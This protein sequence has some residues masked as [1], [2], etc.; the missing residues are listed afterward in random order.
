[1]LDFF[2]NQFYLLE[3]I[4][5]RHTFPKVLRFVW[6][7]FYFALAFWTFYQNKIIIHLRKK[8]FV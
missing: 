7:F 1:M 8:N 2:F 6:T 5:K 3:T 4:K